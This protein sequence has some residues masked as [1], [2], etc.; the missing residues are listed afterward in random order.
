MTKEIKIKCPG[1]KKTF[2]YYSSNFRPFCC[3]KCKMI[4]LGNWFNEGYIVPGQ[5]NTVYIEDPEL[6]GYREEDDC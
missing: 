3:E 1:C 2:L 6:V 5:S 4:D